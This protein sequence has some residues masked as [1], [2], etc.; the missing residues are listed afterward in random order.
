MGCKRVAPSQNTGRRPKVWVCA[1]SARPI[2]LELESRGWYE[3]DASHQTA[4]DNTTAPINPNE[5][6]A[7]ASDQQS[8]VRCK[9]RTGDIGAKLRGDQVTQ[10]HFGAPS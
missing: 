5:A 10:R 9:Q 7:C 2:R 1:G 4:K 3:W 8:G 6:S